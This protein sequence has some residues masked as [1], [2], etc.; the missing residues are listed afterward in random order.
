MAS[1][2]LSTSDARPFFEQAL[3]YGIRNGVITPERLQHILAEGPKGIVQI[4]NYFGTAHLRAELEI[5]SERMVN[6][7]S[8][9][10]ADLSNGDLRSAASSLQRNS[11]LSHSKGG[12]DLLRRLSALPSIPIIENH[13]QSPEDQRNDLNEWTFAG[14]LDAQTYRSELSIRQSVQAEI[15]FARWLLKK[16]G[17][18][19]ADDQFAVET[20]AVINSA[21]LV[22]SV[23]DAPLRMP[24][25]VDFVRLVAALQKKRTHQSAAQW[26]AFLADLPPAY[27][28]MAEKMADAFAR[29]VLPAIRVGDRTAD[30]LLY[31]DHA[32][33]V[34]IR[35]D[36][37]EDSGEYDRQVSS[38]WYRIT[39]G[40][41]E[42]PEVIATILFRVA[43]GLVPKSKLLKREARE[44]VAAFRLNGFDSGAV[45]EFIET[46][47]PL[48]SQPDLKRIWK[49][50]LAPDASES[51]S[52]NDSQFPDKYMSRA[53]AYLRKACR[54]GWTVDDR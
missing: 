6:L 9:Y 41:A 48:Q 54:A 44:M 35:E 12:S 37:D 40:D 38:A 16:F 31:G 14:A 33:N 49:E 51:L 36:L 22:L 26:Q 25:R 15:E 30:E 24:T 20:H 10:L 1:T 11:L 21:M 4:A 17:A 27:A 42:D 47:A 18:P 45:N 39:S 13:R 52:D 23:K 43:T 8:L 19:A 2:S 29:D 34:Y 5:A 53:I 7:L 50:D 46:H 32:L 3:R 28:A